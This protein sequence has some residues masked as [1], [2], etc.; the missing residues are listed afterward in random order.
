VAIVKRSESATVDHE[1]RRRPRDLDGLTAELD[2]TNP[3]ARR[4]AA[5]DLAP[6]GEAAPALIERL[7]DELDATVREAIL[8]SLTEIGSAIAVQGLVNCLRSEDVALRNEA[9]E[10]MKR[11]PEAVAPIMAGLLADPDPD[12]RIF[13][14]NVLES[15]RHP[16][17]ERWLIGVIGD[18]A[19][20]NVC[21]TAVDLL[22][23]VGSAAA[24]TQLEALKH[25]FPGEPYIQF[26]ADLALRRIR[27]D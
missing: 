13:A 18:D 1:E 20:V 19:H 3:V 9:I 5:H 16:D 12:V 10:A 25:R 2:D 14:V 6:F 22:G 23:E 17:V 4:W 11:L 24:I 26:A 8:I 27:E 7:A 15:L 21:A